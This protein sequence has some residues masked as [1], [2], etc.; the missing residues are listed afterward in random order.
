MNIKSI[1][2]KYKYFLIG[3]LVLIIVSLTL[4]SSMANLEG[5]KEGATSG[6]TTTTNAATNAATSAAIKTPTS[7]ATNAA[8][9]TPTS[10]PTSA[11]TNAAI[12]TPT[13]APT[14][15]ATSAAI[16]TPTSA[17]TIAPIKTPTSAAIKTP[18]SVATIAPIKTPT[19]AAIKTPTNA[20]TP[21][22]SS[23]QK[24]QNE[25][26]QLKAQIDLI[27]QTTKDFE[28]ALKQM[29]THVVTDLSGRTFR[30]TDE[31]TKGNTPDMNGKKLIQDGA[32]AALMRSINRDGETDPDKD[33]L[34]GDRKRL[35]NDYD[36]IQSINNNLKGSVTI[37]NQNYNNIASY[38]K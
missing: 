25:L 29:N 1:I 30:I 22:L 18:T 15:A 19:S 6:T 34:T 32:K 2:L 31:I 11:A 9:K 12:K 28:G 8:I 26:M 21:T 27:N 16:K 4:N 7:A 37:L 17:A 24:I 33:N 36:A 38:N 3:A 14:S 10:A 13:S 35:K 5:F 23:Q 20:P